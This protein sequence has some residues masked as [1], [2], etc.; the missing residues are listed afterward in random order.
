MNEHFDLIV[1]GGGSAAR[2][3]ARKAATEHGAKVALVES[4]RWGGSCPNVACKP[5]KAYL[6]AADL[7]R[8]LRILGP[9]LGLAPPP[10][11]ADLAQ[12]RTWKDSLRKPQEKWVADLRG[13]GFETIDGEATIVDKHTL[14]VEERELSGDRILIATGSRTAVPPIDGLEEAGWI[15]HVSALELTELPE[16]LFVL[17]GGPVGLEFAQAFRRFGSQVTIVQSNDRIS[18][19]S[20]E[21]ATDALAAALRDD[22]IEIVT[23]TTVERIEDG[24]AVL[25][26]GRHLA[27]GRIFLA[28]GRKP[29][30]EALRLDDIGIERHKLGI[31]VDE[32]MRTSVEGVW[33]AGD[34]TGM[35]QFTPI[36][37]YQARIAIK[38]MFGGNGPAAEY[39]FL[40]TAIF[41]DP[42]LASV[43]LTEREAAEQETEYETVIQPVANVTR[44]QYV[45][46]KNGLYKAVFDRSS[47]RVLGVHVVSRN[48]SDVVQ[49]LSL[50]LRLGATIDDLAQMHHIYPSWGEGVKAAAEQAKIKVEA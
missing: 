42:E 21:D 47:R 17:G 25:A 30:I 6:V 5:T 27:A 18:P 32:H 10:D 48:A 16:S 43:G 45:R 9:T 31:V 40:P 50:A 49:G 22:G 38:D 34:V 20:D 26:D 28:S 33:A 36:A 11:R 7:I 8:D 41:T 37:Q 3:G 39:S 15:D 1:L 29:N 44:S 19:R 13:N 2:D 24:A 14:K 4:T 12:I 46:E 23:G 35:N